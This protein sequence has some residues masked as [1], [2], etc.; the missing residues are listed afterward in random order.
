MELYE[1]NDIEPGNCNFNITQRDETSEVFG[2]MSQKDMIDTMNPTKQTKSTNYISESEEE[3]ITPNS[4]QLLNKKRKN[5]PKKESHIKYNDE[6]IFNEITYNFANNII[7]LCNRTAKVHKISQEIQFCSI[8][9]FENNMK[10]GNTIKDFLLTPEINWIPIKNSTTNTETLKKIDES[11]IYKAIFKPLFKINLKDYYIYIF[12]RG[13]NIISKKFEKVIIKMKSSKFNWS[14]ILQKKKNAALF[15]E[16][17][18]KSFISEFFD[19][20]E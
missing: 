4:C 12:L 1:S 20:E 19:S 8:D 13:C 10:F 16:K 17:A 6:N 2:G 5:S 9:R 11:C 18:E 3:Q 14:K 7:D 15:E